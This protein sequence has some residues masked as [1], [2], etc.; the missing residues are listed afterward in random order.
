[1]S[2]DVE[3]LD[4]VGFIELTGLADAGELRDGLGATS[5]GSLVCIEVECLDGLQENSVGR[6]HW[7]VVSRCQRVPALV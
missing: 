2:T 5:G 3:A 7:V 1:M 6:H 4:C